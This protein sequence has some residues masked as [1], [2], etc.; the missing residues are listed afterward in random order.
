M[1]AVRT[2]QALQALQA[3]TRPVAD[4][5]LR[6]MGNSCRRQHDGRRV[7]RKDAVMSVLSTRLTAK[8]AHPYPFACAGMAFVGETPDLAV[9]VTNAGGIGAIG[10]GIMPPSR[11]REVIREVGGRTGGAPF[12][13]NLITAIGTVEQVAVC[14]EERVPIVSFHWGH[15]PTDWL[16]PLQEAGVSVWE[17][18]GS[19]D[20]ARL[21]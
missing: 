21:A 20:A 1:G 6:L 5:A 8:Y 9:A 12:N 13:V 2:L 4:R 18:I 14:V 3:R 19:A 15:P 11:L 17:Q 7:S 10:A 16:K